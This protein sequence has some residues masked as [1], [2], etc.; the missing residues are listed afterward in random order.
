MSLFSRLKSAA[1]TLQAL[2]VVLAFSLM[3][4]VSYFFVES[5]QRSNLRRATV[6]ALTFVQSKV[7]ADMQESELLMSAISYTISGML[8]LGNDVAEVAS[9]IEF[10]SSSVVK[11]EDSNS[12]FYGVCGLFH[13]FGDTLICDDGWSVPKDYDFRTRP[14][15]KAAIEAGGAVVHTDPF[16][17]ARDSK[18]IVTQTRTLMDSAGTVLA[19]INFDRKFDYIANYVTGMHLAQNSYGALMDKETRILAHPNKDMVGMKMSETRGGMSRLAETLQRDR[20]ITERE[21]FNH[22]NDK[23]IVSVR[24]MK[25]GWYIAIL[26]SKTSYYSGMRTMAFV[27]IALGALLATILN[28]ILVS[29]ARAKRKSDEFMHV[30]FNATPLACHMW[31]R[32]GQAIFCNN[33]AVRM[34]GAADHKEVLTSFFKTQ[35]EFQPDGRNSKDLALSYLEKAF[36]EGYHSV[37][38]MHQKFSG[39]P[40]PC[41]ITM[42]R[43]TYKGETVVLVYTQDLRE[44]KSA[45]QK[46]READIRNQVMLDATPLCANFWDKGFNHVDCNQEA[47]RMFGLSGKKE[48]SD[49]FH[50]LS[51]E[52]QPDGKPSQ[53]KAIEL[54]KKAFAEGYAR[55]EWMHIKPD[56]GE[57]IPCEI[58]LVRVRF[59]EDFIV[60]GYT[61]DLRELKAANEKLREADERTALML[62]AAPIG[63]TLWDKSLNLIDFNMEAAR[64]VGIYDKQEYKDKFAMLTPEFQPD[65]ENSLQKIATFLGKTF[66]EGNMHTTWYHNHINGEPI[67]YDA[68]AIRLKYK[69]DDIAM[70]CCRDLREINAANAKLREADERAKLMLDATPVSCTLFDDQMNA[71]D[72][73]QE[74][75]KLLGV[76]S[77][78]EFLKNFFKYSPECQPDG[79]TSLEKGKVYVKKALEDGFCRFEWVH[80]SSS[81][82][83]VP[84]EVT[85]VRVKYR[86]AYGVA[87]YARDQRELKAMI[88]EMNRAEVAEESNKAKSRFLA[89]MSHEIRTPMNVILGVTEIQLQDETLTPAIREAFVQ[90]YNSSDMLLGIINDILDLS[91]IE[92]DRVEFSPVKYDLASLI[93]DTAHLN[94]MRNSKPIVFELNIDENAPAHLFGDEL[95]IKQILNNLLSNA[96]KFTE[97]GNIKLAVSVADGCD[98]DSGGNDSTLILTVADTGQ[99]MSTEQVNRL[100]TE[101]TRF[102][103]EVNRAVEGTGL[104]MNITRRLISMMGGKI[105]VDSEVGKGTTVVVHLPQKRVSDERIGKDLAENLRKFRVV[106]TTGS[107]AQITREYMP[108]GKVLVVDDVESNLYVAKGLLAPYGLTVDIATDGFEAL[109]KVKYGEEYDVIF[110][111]HMMPKMDGIEAT[112]EIRMLGY[113]HPIIALT[114]NAVVGQA[115]IFLKSGFNDFISKP[116]DIRQL[117]AALNRFIRDKQAPETIEKARKQNDATLASNAAKAQAPAS[118]AVTAELL[119]IF[120]RDAQRV[121][122]LLQLAAQNIAKLSEP[123]LRL[124]T[125]NVHGMKA[126]LANIGETQ[127]AQMAQT[128]EKAGK[129][130]DRRTLT[131]QAMNFVKALR[132]VTEKAEATSKF[133]NNDAEQD[134]CPVFLKEQMRV[135]ADACKNYDEKTALDALKDLKVMAWTTETRETLDKI[136]ELLLHSEFD[137]VAEIAGKMI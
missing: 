93:N 20:Q 126:A 131:V 53:D 29:I 87:G 129:S 34:Y 122:P 105:T 30:V 46:M 49:R 13:V 73:N 45:L 112:R 95:R 128:L 54:V 120:A 56:S 55:F 24:E 106:S 42:V 40:L 125:T 81:G 33:E 50:E 79:C 1:M 92:A 96:F 130:G 59:K 109:D 64:S 89:A 110:M 47:V 114:A 115:D 72:C 65:G 137:E 78:K 121:L 2:F 57:H 80:L 18:R 68:T 3:V 98:D 77:R 16:V 88:K 119:A 12:K 28:I 37:E 117:N 38:W 127:L 91:K 9:Y 32:T 5:I 66:E 7:E 27:L 74:A 25:N 76:S 10:I 102:N 97:A 107:R 108:Y 14:W 124:F 136:S 70:V 101:Y 84:V 35:P 100:F 60:A 118:T 44:Q 36:T 94:M 62:D 75:L 8:Y 133:S 52:F 85:L 51:P 86:S 48:Y 6:G 135:I 123:E 22:T 61:R 67:P 21:L 132:G 39:E 31:N 26:T 69:G 103:L 63:I 19:V 113:K 82:E 43:T 134:E 71:I 23:Y 41:Q 104:G 4:I 17:S 58:T 116:I 83:Q 90:V 99:G 15:Y 111:D 11:T